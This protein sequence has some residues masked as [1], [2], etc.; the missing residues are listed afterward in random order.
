L[1]SAL[2]YM[3][4]ILTVTSCNRVSSRLVLAAFK[5]DII[6]SGAREYMKN[7]APFEVHSGCS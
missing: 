1:S 3:S 2:T 6:P 4:L 7:R 5:S